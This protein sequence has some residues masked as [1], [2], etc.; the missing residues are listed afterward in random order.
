M[1]VSIDGVIKSDEEIAMEQQ[2]QQMQMQQQQQMDIAKSAMP[3]AISN[4]PA[5]RQ[6]A[7][8]M[9]K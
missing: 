7:D 9:P 3:A 2:Q 8:E 4:M 1:N 5:L 6:M